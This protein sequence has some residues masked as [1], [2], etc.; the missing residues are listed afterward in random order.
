MRSI[1]IV[2]SICALLAGCTSQPKP[3]PTPE[4]KA[5]QAVILGMMLLASAA[6]NK[7]SSAR[8]LVEV[9][10][11]PP[12][13]EILGSVARFHQTNGKWP[14]KDDIIVPEGVTDIALTESA[15]QL[16]IGVRNGDRTLLRCHMITDGTVILEPFAG[17]FM[18]IMQSAAEES[19]GSSWPMPAY[20]PPPK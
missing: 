3:A 16:E 20:V 11:T 14:K 7:D 5:D 15:T 13:L 6:Q 1:I 2:S 17:D 4:K 12:A 19:R 8:Q 18:R 9:K 10:I